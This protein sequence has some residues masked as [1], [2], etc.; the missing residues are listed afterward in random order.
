MPSMRSCRTSR[1]TK[2]W[3]CSSSEY[4]EVSSGGPCNSAD[5]FLSSSSGDASHVMTF[6]RSFCSSFLLMPWTSGS[7]MP[8]Y[9]STRSSVPKTSMHSLRASLL[10]RY[11]CC[12]SSSSSSSS[13]TCT[14]RAAHSS[15]SSA[16][17][18][19]CQAS[20]FLRS[21][22]SSGRFRAL[23][24]GRPRPS[25]HSLSA[26]APMISRHSCSTRRR[27]S[28]CCRSSCPCAPAW[29]AGI[30]RSSHC[31]RRS[32]SGE[33][34]QARIFLR[35]FW[36]AALSAPS[37]EGRPMPAYHAKSASV[38]IASMLSCKSSLWIMDCCASCCCSSSS[39]SGVLSSATAT[40]SLEHSC[41]KSARGSTS[42]AMT[43]FRRL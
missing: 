29:P 26:S 11:C 31:R 19:A 14:S 33:D 4:S 16:G 41:R 15:W 38:L 23:A 13:L 12:S 10:S 3:R 8:W 22:W 6:L 21:P 17:A 1:C 30:P 28:A 37:S 7:P 9:H 18:R 5:C 40:P 42:Q 36:M 34:S 27:A 24:A 32:G 43:F 35:S 2:D 39:S 25:Y 20:T